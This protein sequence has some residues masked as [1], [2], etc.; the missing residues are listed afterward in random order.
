MS[1]A[2][3]AQPAP[4]EPAAATATPAPAATPSPAPT[5][6]A[7]SAAPAANAE[8]AAPDA[9][10]PA[11]PVNAAPEKY[12]FNAPEG[13]QLDGEVMSAFEGVARDLGLPQDKAQS[14][15]D[16][17]APVLAARQTAAFEAVKT[18]WGNAAKADTEIGGEAFDANLAI[19]KQGMD[20]LF[21]PEFTQFLNSTGLGNHPEMIRGC[22]RY[23]KTLAQD[24]GVQGRHSN[25]KPQDPAKRMYPSMA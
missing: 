2:L 21:T 14:V 10:K 20:A 17:V 6:P 8:P 16:K 3:P 4:T 25:G 13:V 11:A 24:P 15:I 7:P 23:G 22:Y 1:D 5:A 9:T 12:E 19:A 18:E